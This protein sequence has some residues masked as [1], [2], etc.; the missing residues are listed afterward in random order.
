MRYKVTLSYDGTE[1]SGWQKQ[2]NAVSVQEVI[3]QKLSV[4]LQESIQVVGCGRTDAGVHASQYVLHFDT[5]MPVS[6]DL[7]HYVNIMLPNSIAFHKI[8]EVETGFHARFDAVSRAYIYYLHGNKNPFKKRFSYYYPQIRFVDVEMLEKT[9]GLI[10][11][12]TDFA[13]FCKTN[14]DVRTMKC[15]LNHILWDK[16][17]EENKLVFKIGADRFLRGMVRLIVG[18]CIQVGMGK[19]SLNDVKYALDNQVP[20]PKPLSVPPEGL[21]LSSVEY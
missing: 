10:G 11:Q 8:E 16:D 9:A 1:F 2:D 20:L 4:K 7:L 19:M 5:G 17:P 14:T 15:Q 13:P 18:T 21:F 12:Y 6:E 3:E